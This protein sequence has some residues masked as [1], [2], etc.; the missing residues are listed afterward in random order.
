MISVLLFAF[1]HP[2]MR[3]LT[4]LDSMVYVDARPKQPNWEELGLASDPMD[5]GHGYQHQESVKSKIFP[6][7]SVFPSSEPIDQWMQREQKQ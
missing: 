3:W 4:H 2:I 7:R 1:L 6:E 5:Y